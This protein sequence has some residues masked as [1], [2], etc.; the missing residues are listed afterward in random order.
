M[1][2]S[3]VHIDIRRAGATRHTHAHH[4]LGPWL[5]L[6]CIHVKVRYIYGLIASHSPLLLPATRPPRPSLPPGLAMTLLQIHALHAHVSLVHSIGPSGTGSSTLHPVRTAGG[7]RRNER[8]RWSGR[9]PSSADA[10]EMRREMDMSSA[11]LSGD[12]M[13]S[14]TYHSAGSWRHCAGQHTRHRR[15]ARPSG[16]E[17]RAPQPTHS[18]ESCRG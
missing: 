3:R 15:W 2:H 8:L 18:I 12:Y 11:A 6:C 5:K 17:T 7:P 1:M 9:C 14:Q 16:C 10:T 13:T 4:T